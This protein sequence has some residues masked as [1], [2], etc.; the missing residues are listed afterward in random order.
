MPM[1]RTTPTTTPKPRRR[2][3]Q[4]S[5]RTLMVLMLLVSVPL[6]WLAVQLKRGRE[7]KQAVIALRKLGGRVGYE[8]DASG[9]L[10]SR[11]PQFVG[12]VE[13]DLY[14]NVTTV[15]L[16]NCLIADLDLGHIR[17]L[18]D[19]QDLDLTN[20]P[21]TVLPGLSWVGSNSPSFPPPQLPRET[22]TEAGGQK[23]L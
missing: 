10:Q 17:G 18:I 4:F 19:I 13:E 2:W 8:R 9:R 14:A 21:I 15:R 6:G 16:S 7:Q 23:S 12:S 11:L 1:I 3:L 20:T 22:V 5:L